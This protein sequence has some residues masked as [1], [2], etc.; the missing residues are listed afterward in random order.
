MYISKMSG[1]NKVGLL[2]VSVLALAGISPVMSQVWAYQSESLIPVVMSKGFR[3]LLKPN[4]ADLDQDGQAEC[5]CLNA[6]RAEI[7]KQ[8]DCNR[9]SPQSVGGEI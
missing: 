1:F 9:N 3:P 7:W 2:F 5:L 4:E 8:P 6:K